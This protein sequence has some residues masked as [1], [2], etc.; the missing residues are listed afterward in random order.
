M[1]WGLRE[2]FAED[3]MYRGELRPVPLISPAFVDW[4]GTGSL[5]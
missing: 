4:V 3:K 2:G 1:G 5:P